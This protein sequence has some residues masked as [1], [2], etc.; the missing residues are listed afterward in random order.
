VD[1]G[2]CPH[3]DGPKR[4]R[5]SLAEF[6]AGER[7]PPP[8]SSEGALIYDAA[9]SLR[10]WGPAAFDTAMP[11]FLEAARWSVLLERLMPIYQSAQ[12]RLSEPLPFDPV[13]KGEVL[14]ARLAAR[15]FTAAWT[16]ILFPE[17][18]DG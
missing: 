2:P 10:G 7:F 18:D 12:A 6:Y 16:P 1:E 17:D 11:D 8:E 3:G 9:L 13:A 4:I 14:K 5:R 15:E